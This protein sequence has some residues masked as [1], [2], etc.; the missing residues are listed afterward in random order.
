MR[1]RAGD[2]IDSKV[3]SF[4]KSHHFS[5]VAK[6]VIKGLKDVLFVDLYYPWTPWSWVVK[7]KLMAV[8][9]YPSQYPAVRI[10]T[11]CI[12][13]VFVLKKCFLQEVSF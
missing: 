2:K 5:E 1:I 9:A 10:A 7:Q 11:N 8:S 12:Q 6:L 4:Y 3:F 13:E